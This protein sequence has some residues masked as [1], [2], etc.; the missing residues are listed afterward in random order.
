MLRKASGLCLHKD[1]ETKKVNLVGSEGWKKWL[2][3]EVLKHKFI[4]IP[5]S[6]TFIGTE[7]AG[8]TSEMTRLNNAV[9]A[10]GS[11]NMMNLW[12]SKGLGIP[13]TS[14]V[15]I[16]N[17]FRF[18]K[19]WSRT[20]GVEMR[21]RTLK[22]MLTEARRFVL[23]NHSVKMTN[24]DLLKT[25]EEGGAGLIWPLGY[26]DATRAAAVLDMSNP[27]MSVS[28]LMRRLRETYEARLPKGIHPI[29]HKL[30]E[31][32]ILKMAQKE[33]Q[34]GRGDGV[35]K[36]AGRIKR[37]YRERLKEITHEKEDGDG[38]EGRGKMTSEDK[39]FN[40]EE[41]AKR[42]EMI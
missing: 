16:A 6:A 42:T 35:G 34:E 14:R 8:L 31:D 37:L 2:V 15:E 20:A 7:V 9:M 26:A 23:V 19:T 39:K 28:L 30:Y 33:E 13:L 1:V 18:S 36:K 29:K 3:P 11:K 22:D 10:K 4:S 21:A 17:T 25:K 12:R 5:K 38:R 27:V 41:R 24:L 40:E 32:R